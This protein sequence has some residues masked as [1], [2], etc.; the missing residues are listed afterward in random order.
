MEL[1]PLAFAF[2]CPLALGADLSRLQLNHRLIHRH[3]QQE[4]LD[5]GREVGPLRAH[6]N[7]PCLVVQPQPEVRER[8]LSLAKGI[9]CHA[10]GDERGLV[11][12]RFDARPTSSGFGIVSGRW[13][14]RTASTGEPPAGR[15]NRA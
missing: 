1:M 8:H 10:G 5:V 9:G 14:I 4:A 6:D 3:A 12:P 15:F 13:A 11:Q 2:L 7:D